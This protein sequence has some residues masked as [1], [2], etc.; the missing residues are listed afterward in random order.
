MARFKLFTLLV[1]INSMFLLTLL[2]YYMASQGAQGR[3]ERSIECLR[4]SNR[5]LAVV[6]DRHEDM[7]KLR[8][9][10]GSVHRFAPGQ[11]IGVFAS[12]T[13][14]DDY[15]EIASWSDTSLHHLG[16]ALYGQHRDDIKVADECDVVNRLLKGADMVHVPLGYKFN[17][18]LNS[19]ALDTLPSGCNKGNFISLAQAGLVESRIMETTKHDS[20]MGVCWLKH[21]QELISNAGIKGQ[22]VTQFYNSSHHSSRLAM[23]NGRR[24]AL[25]IPTYNK[26]GGRIY[27]K[28]V[29]IPSLLATLTSQEESRFLVTLYI[30]YDSN[31]PIV[32][33]NFEE[34]LGSHHNVLVKLH[35]LP[36]MRWATSMWNALYVDAMLDKNDYYMQLGDDVQFNNKGWMTSMVVE[37]DKMNGFGMVGPSDTRWKCDMLTQAMVTRKHY[38]IFGFFYPPEI[39]DWFSD[40]WLQTIYKNVGMSRCTKGHTITNQSGLEKRYQACDSVILANQA[41]GNHLPRLLDYVK[42]H[43]K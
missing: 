8:E 27:L 16:L 5:T 19:T 40:N 9:F 38:E 36:A 15:E 33:V 7:W 26:N 29:L 41:L 22:Q 35:R 30:G 17:G 2:Y 6:I 20:Q 21:R 42:I 18:T 25:M 32:A 23:W 14:H 11:H 1:A 4:A 12:L 24:V 10:V 37:L 34:L 13:N 43:K 39:K 3:P 31:D 28:E